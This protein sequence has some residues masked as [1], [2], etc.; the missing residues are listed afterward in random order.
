MIGVYLVITVLVVSMLLLMVAALLPKAR[1]YKF[2][3][4]VQRIE[5]KKKRKPTL[6]KKKKSVWVRIL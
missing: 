3:S 6:K 5:P 4:P 2:R 1:K